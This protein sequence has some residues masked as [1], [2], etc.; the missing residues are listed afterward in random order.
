MEI[1]RDRNRKRRGR[2]EDIIK[3][4]NKNL[5]ILYHI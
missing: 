1:K 2:E 5:A 4:I 3:N